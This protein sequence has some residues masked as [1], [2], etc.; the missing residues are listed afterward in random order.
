MPIRGSKAIIFQG[1]GEGFGGRGGVFQGFS[2]MVFVGSG[3][4]KKLRE[5]FSVRY[6]GFSESVFVGSGF[7]K[8]YGKIFVSDTKGFRKVSK[9]IR[10]ASPY[11]ENRKRRK[12]YVR[13]NFEYFL[14][15]CFF[16]YR[17][18]E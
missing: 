12:G 2:E 5:K 3:F 7:Q 8:N 6:E 4:Q 18:K 14:E 10:G 11:N 17:R 1:A 9:K 16:L 15:R 13:G